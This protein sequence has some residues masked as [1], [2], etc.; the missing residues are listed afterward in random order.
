MNFKQNIPIYLQI[1]DRIMDEILTGV[2]PVNGRIPSVREYSV[3]LEVNVNTMVKVYDHLT[4]SGLIYIKRGLGYFV[5]E[6]APA[7]I[8]QMRKTQ[9]FTDFLP[10][11]AEKMQQLD[12]TEE[13][14][15]KELTKYLN[16]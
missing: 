16:K 3:A 5:C 13:D 6:S 7:Q 8:R 15:K 10:Q 12:I 2:Y 1:A 4:S 11:L 14:L 9:F